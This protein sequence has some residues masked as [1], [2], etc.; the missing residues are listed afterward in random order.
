MTFR[1]NNKSSDRMRTLETK[2]IKRPEASNDEP[3]LI[4]DGEYVSLIHEH[5]VVVVKPKIETCI[6]VM[7]S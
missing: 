3:M 6:R 7:R 5:S 2:E 4:P 1:V